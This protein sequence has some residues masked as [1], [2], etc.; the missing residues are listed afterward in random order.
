MQHQA[1][2]LAGVVGVSDIVH[3]ENVRA[4]VNLKQ[5]AMPPTAIELI[6]FARARVDYKAPKDV[7]FLDQMPMNAVG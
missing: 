6:A 4:F 2:A 3:G 7:L 5:K 1:V